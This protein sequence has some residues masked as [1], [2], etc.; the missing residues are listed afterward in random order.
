MK[1]DLFWTTFEMGFFLDIF[2]IWSRS[3]KVYMSVIN[4][5]TKSPKERLTEQIKQKTY[6]ANKTK[7]L[8]SK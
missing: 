6:R 3:T 8:Q 7:D 5:L 2:G 4:L 1:F